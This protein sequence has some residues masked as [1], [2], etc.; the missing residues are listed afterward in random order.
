MVAKFQ[1]AMHLSRWV[2]APAWDRCSWNQETAA[3]GHQHKRPSA[4]DSP[5]IL[6]KLREVTQ[7]TPAWAVAW[8]STA[9]PR[10][11]TSRNKTKGGHKFP[12][13]HGAGKPGESH[14]RNRP[15]PLPVG[16]GTDV[17]SEYNIYSLPCRTARTQTCPA[18]RKRIH[19]ARPTN[20]S[21]LATRTLAAAHMQR[22]GETALRAT[23]YV[24]VMASRGRSFRRFFPVEERQTQQ[25]PPPQE[26]GGDPGALCLCPL[27]A[28]RDFVQK[29]SASTETDLAQALKE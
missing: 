1:S 7:R 14:Y 15:A 3:S 12:V 9:S 24:K 29:A 22:E 27:A 13:F 18:C 4:V 23:R 21:V 25:E 2:G 8:A 11:L 17:R 19:K 16:R 28:G 20:L 5:C 10:T 6:I 26:G